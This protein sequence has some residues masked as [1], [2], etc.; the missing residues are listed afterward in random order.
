VHVVDGFGPKDKA[1]IKD[2]KGPAEP[3]AKVVLGTYDRETVEITIEDSDGVIFD[4]GSSRQR[5]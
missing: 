5:R 3:E 4:S 2:A 1:G